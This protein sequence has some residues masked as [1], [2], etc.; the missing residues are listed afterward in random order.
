MACKGGYNGGGDGHPSTA[1][2]TST[3][4]SQQSTS[5]GGGATHIATVSG[6]L[7]NLSSYKDTG[8]TNVSN[9]ILIVSGGGGGYGEC[10]IPGHSTCGTAVHGYGGAGGGISGNAGTS[11]ND[12]WN[13]TWGGSGANQTSSGRGQT[14]QGSLYAD[15]YGGFG[16]GGTGRDGTG[17]AN[18]DNGG[19]G[20]FYG[21]GGSV[22][23]HNGAG[24]GSGY[25]GSSSLIQNTTN[26][27]TNKMY[28]FDCQ[29]SS[30]LKTYTT[31]THGTTTHNDR[32]TVNCP[33]GYS[34]DPISMCAKSGHGYARITL[35]SID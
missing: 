11:T 18:G 10:N 1:M 35:I 15:T 16:Y 26:N 13:N 24:G 3:N 27:I 33:N 2:V 21:G 29:E 25:I 14:N 30:D 5:G 8:G 32:D 12:G 23:G 22:R 20:G 9:E 19:G 6:L 28:C 4:T 34:S 17:G 31:S 7:S